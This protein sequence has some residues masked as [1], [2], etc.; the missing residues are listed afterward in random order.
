[1]INNLQQ[2]L[3]FIELMD[4]MKDI[5]RAIYLKNWKHET[6]AEHSYH[7]AMMILTF[8][9]DFPELDIEKCL[10]FALI[11][12]LVEIY[13]WDTVAIVDVKWLKTKAKREHEVLLRLEEEF[14]EVLWNIIELIKEY[15]S[16]ES[17]EAK[18]VYSLDKVQPIIQN[19]LEWWKAW[20]EYGYEFQK[21]KEV[22]YSKLF[23][24]FG[25]NKILDIYFKKAEKGWMFYS[26]KV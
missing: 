15:E 11:H 3:K 10:K 25:L 1:M 20:N 21:T 22:S 12:D 5:E 26:E 2:K 9:D 16:K 8:I 13:A 17:R 14:W 23:P 4:K 7:L 6:N 19:V 24:E 18:F